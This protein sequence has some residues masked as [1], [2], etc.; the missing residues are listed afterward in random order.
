[1]RKWL[2]QRRNE[3]RL[4]QEE[5]ARLAG[6]HRGSYSNI[7]IGKRSPSV[8]LAKKIAV[9]LGFDWT[10]FFDSHVVEMKQMKQQGEKNE[11]QA[12]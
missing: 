7:E 8:R 5:V 9:A 12:S 11:Q 3:L 6:I 10:L 2:L 1:M 4:S